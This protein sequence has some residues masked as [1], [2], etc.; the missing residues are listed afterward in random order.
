MLLLNCYLHLQQVSPTH[1]ILYFE[2]TPEALLFECSAGLQ[3]FFLSVSRKVSGSH[4]LFF[5]VFIVIV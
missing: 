5:Q 4:T 1:V 2:C 3:S